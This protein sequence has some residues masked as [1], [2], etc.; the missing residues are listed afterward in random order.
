MQ[1]QPL[2][3]QGDKASGVGGVEP[4]RSMAGALRTVAQPLSSQSFEIFVPYR[5]SVDAYG[6]EKTPN[7][8]TTLA[9]AEEAVSLLALTEE[10]EFNL[11]SPFH[12]DNISPLLLWISHVSNGNMPMSERLEKSK[13]EVRRLERL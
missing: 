10:T 4:N 7:A 11:S 1:Y 9:D 5:R 2:D 8:F 3:V 12:V 6:V 13:W